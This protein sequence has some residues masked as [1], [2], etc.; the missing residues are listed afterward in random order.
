MTQELDEPFVDD[1]RDSLAAVMAAKKSTQQIRWL[2]DQLRRDFK[3]VPEDELLGGVVA[4]LAGRM[5]LLRIIQGIQVPAVQGRH[6]RVAEV[7]KDVAEIEGEF[8]TGLKR[9]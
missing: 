1:R 7:R 9:S 5:P 6:D 2:L 3:D 8:A 4:Q